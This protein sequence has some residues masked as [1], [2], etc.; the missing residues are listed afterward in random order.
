MN[1]IHYILSLLLLIILPAFRGAAAE[2][3]GMSAE[4]SVTATAQV[5]EAYDIDFVDCQPL[6]PGGEREM[7]KFI[8]QERCYPASAYQAGIQGRV[9]CGFI[10]NTDGSLSHISVVRG[11]CADLD[12][13]AVRVISKMPSWSPGSVGEKA[14]PVYCLVA[15]PFRK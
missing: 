12:R 10:V 14:V 2:P 9:V 5:V 3:G 7:I 8:N 6:F 4:I 11:V 1:H 15:V 13:E